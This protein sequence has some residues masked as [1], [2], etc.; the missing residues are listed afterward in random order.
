MG[1]ARQVDVVNAF[2]VPLPT[3]KRYLKLLRDRGSRAFFTEPQRRSASVL[4]GE[5]RQIA[6]R[7]LGE[8]GSVPEAAQASGLKAN[9]LHKAIRA[10]R[11]PGVKKKLVLRSQRPSPLKANG[12]R[13]TVQP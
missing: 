9:T 11:M 12:A 2:G 13:S 10:G 5:A 8:G 3:V 4:Q 7:V 1:V 6:E